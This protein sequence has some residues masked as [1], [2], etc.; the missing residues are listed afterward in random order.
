[1]PRSCMQPA[2]ITARTE[3]PPIVLIA[4][5]PDEP[6]G[7]RSGVTATRTTRKTSTAV[8]TS[9]SVRNAGRRSRLQ[10]ARGHCGEKAGTQHGEDEV[11]DAAAH[12]GRTTRCRVS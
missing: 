8:Y 6:S 10:R 11:P 12:R 9:A 7:L 1:M 5:L 3:K 2:T 4:E